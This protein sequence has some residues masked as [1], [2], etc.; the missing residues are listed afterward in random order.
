MN[1]QS[2]TDVYG[3]CSN[4][5]SLLGRLAKGD[6]IPLTVQLKPLV[7]SSADIW[8]QHHGQ[9]LNDKQVGVELMRS[10]PHSSANV[11]AA[12]EKSHTWLTECLRSQ[13]VALHTR[14]SWR[15]LAC[16]WYGKHLHC[17]LWYPHQVQLDRHFVGCSHKGS[18]SL[19]ILNLQVGLLLENSATMGTF[20]S[21]CQCLRQLL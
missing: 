12:V 9:D 13:V 11:D 19:I 17:M 7:E 5:E 15:P 16:D 1:W 14:P 21:T 2:V 6:R 3:C 4:T 20:W 10:C 8:T 18:H